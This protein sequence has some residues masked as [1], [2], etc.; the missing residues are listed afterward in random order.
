L[1]NGA[2]A[3]D[4]KTTFESIGTGLVNAKGVRGLYF[5]LTALLLMA[6]GCATVS[7]SAAPAWSTWVQLQ[8]GIVHGAEQ[9]RATAA[10]CRLMHDGP[11]PVSIS[12]LAS[13]RIGAW[14]W[15]DGSIF[16]THGLV[17]LLEDDQ[18]SAVIAHEM[19]HLRLEGKRT[20][21]TALDGS[22]AGVEERADAEGCN[23]LREAGVPVQ[24]LA[25]ALAKVRTS[26]GI[27][28]VLAAQ[29][30]ARIALIPSR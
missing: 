25:T 27:S 21:L 26:P 9:L 5:S 22:A 3:N 2:S 24:C 7:S 8:G 16:V 18:L 12:V 30:R 11:K 13:N 14:S 19:G 6:G 1:G 15:N 29:I 23:V 17:L 4:T 20:K 28:P 10:M